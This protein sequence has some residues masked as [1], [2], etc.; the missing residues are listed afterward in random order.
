MLVAVLPAL[1]DACVLLVV[2]GRADELALR[3]LLS[4]L[5]QLIGRATERADDDDRLPIA[6]L[7]D[8]RRRSRD[9]FRIAD[10]SSAELADD[11]ALFT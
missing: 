3:R 2:S 9:R 1:R 10:G 5:E 11:H 4:D 8:D 7:S 6:S